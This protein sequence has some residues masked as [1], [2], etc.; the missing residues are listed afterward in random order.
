MPVGS[1]NKNTLEKRRYYARYPEKKAAMYK[2]YAAKP[3]KKEVI[4]WRRHRYHSKE[5]GIEF[6]LTF[7]QWKTIWD[8]SGHAHE[9]GSLQ[10]NYCM[11]RNQDRGP[12]AIG[13]VEIIT[14]RENNQY[15]IHQ[16]RHNA[17]SALLSFSS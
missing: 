12:Y 13:N 16:K 14:A 15:P 10:H 11:A 17:A 9:R 5:R 6:L 8:S 1:P 7:D 4:A 3:E 2:R